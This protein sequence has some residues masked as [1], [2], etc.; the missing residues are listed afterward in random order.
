MGFFDGLAVKSI[1][2]VMDQDRRPKVSLD[3]C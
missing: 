1:R 3:P 2:I